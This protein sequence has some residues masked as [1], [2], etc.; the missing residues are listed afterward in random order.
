METFNVLIF[1]SLILVTAFC[2][3]IVHKQKDAVGNIVF[4]GQDY[5]QMLKGIAIII[6]MLGHCSGL[7][8]C[9]RLLTPFGGIGVSLFLIMSGYG[10]NESYLKR[11]LGGFW[12]KRFSKVYIPYIIAAL[13][14]V[15]TGNISISGGNSVL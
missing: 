10:L 15:L 9:G 3:K 4:M 1:T 2:S 5:T 6:I 7:W 11:G 13:I 8:V 14:L 12:K